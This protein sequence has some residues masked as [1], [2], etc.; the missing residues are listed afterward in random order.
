M[1]GLGV[2][3]QDADQKEEKE[4]VWIQD[5]CQE[6]LAGG[7]MKFVQ[8]VI[9]EGKFYGFAVKAFDLA[10]VQL[11]QQIRVVAGD[12]VNQMPRE[13]FIFGECLR[14]GDR[15]LRAFWIAVAL[16]RETTEEAGRVVI[17]FLA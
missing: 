10:P 11:F 9:L 16:F 13:R 15:S 2:Q 6:V 7:E 5:A 12:Q 17:G 1:S 4:D 8:A 3:A 14:V